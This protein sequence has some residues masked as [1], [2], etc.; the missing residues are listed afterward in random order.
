MRG[1]AHAP[2]EQYLASLEKKRQEKENKLD[3]LAPMEAQSIRENLTD[4]IRY[5]ESRR[6]VYN[7][8]LVAI[9]LVCFAVAYPASKA[10]ISFNGIL[11][12]FLLAVLA[13]VAYCAAYIVDVFAQSLGYRETWRKRRWV[14]FAIGMLFAAAL[15]WF[16]AIGMFESFPQ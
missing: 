2:A 16:W 4:A 1:G 3:Y 11:F 10:S 9:V 6:L 5:W 15:T 8:V 14:L 12:I 13:N 7:A